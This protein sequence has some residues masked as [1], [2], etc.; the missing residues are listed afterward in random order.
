MN[1]MM[2]VSGLIPAGAKQVRSL[3]HLNAHGG[4]AHPH[5]LHDEHGRPGFQAG[6]IELH[7]VAV[8]ADALQQLD[9]LQRHNNKHSS[10]QLFEQRTGTIQDT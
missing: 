1:S 7:N 8:M 6:A 4:L 5:V 3:N 2:S 9:L 10:E